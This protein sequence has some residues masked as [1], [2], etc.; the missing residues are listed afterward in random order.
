MCRYAWF[1]LC[2][3]LFQTK[4]PDVFRSISETV[5]DFWA[6]G[7]IP[8]PHIGARFPISEVSSK[9][10][11]NCFAEFGWHERAFHLTFSAHC[12]FVR[13]VRS[14]MLLKL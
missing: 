8:S 7:K 9:I 13:N 1:T 10:V 5:L 12:P 14:I 6:Q 3:R 11:S 4:R 2:V